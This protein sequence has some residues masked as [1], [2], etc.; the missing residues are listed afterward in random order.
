MIASLKGQLSDWQYGRGI[1]KDF[2]NYLSD[3]A[4][5]KPFP[6]KNLNS[7]RKQ[8]RELIQIEAC[9]VEA[10]K[11][12]KIQFA[13]KPILD[14]SKTAL[15]DK[16]EVWDASLE[17]ILEKFVGSETIDWFGEDWNI[18]RHLC[19]MI[20]HEQMHIGQIVAFC[21]AIDIQIPEEIVNK[22]ALDG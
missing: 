12:G 16:M 11:T 5:D 13:S 18:H 10:L 4:L 9:Y 3:S 7:I 21:Y 17:E 19:A 15:L 2:L 20:G 22:M 14:I 6:R 8:C 1:I